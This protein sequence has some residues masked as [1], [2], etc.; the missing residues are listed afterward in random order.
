MHTFPPRLAEAA[1]MRTPAISSILVA[2]AQLSH[3]ST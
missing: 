1:Q 3:E 2:T